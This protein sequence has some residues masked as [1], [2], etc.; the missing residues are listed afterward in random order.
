MYACRNIHTKYILLGLHSAVMHDNRLLFGSHYP[1]YSDHGRPSAGFFSRGGQI[2]GLETKLPAVSMD[3][4]G[5]GAKL[6]EA[7]GRL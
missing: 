4:G 5:L 6:P 7:E 3:G 2:T 1:S